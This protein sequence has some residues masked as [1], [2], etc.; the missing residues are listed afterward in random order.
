M[1]WTV[2]YQEKII[3]RGKYYSF[4][5][6]YMFFG[7]SLGLMLVGEMEEG[8]HGIGFYCGNVLTLNAL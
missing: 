1:K 2:L 3:S 8:A 5:L 7:V 4:H 6:V